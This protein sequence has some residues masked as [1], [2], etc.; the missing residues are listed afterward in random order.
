[1]TARPFR[2][3]RAFTLIELLVV[4]AI[5]AILIGLLL[6][7]VQKVRDAAAR[8]TSSNNLKQMGLAYANHAG[9]F[10]GK[11]IGR[12]NVPVFGA[13]APFAELLPY[14]E[15]N[16]LYN[17]QFSATATQKPGGTPVKTF[18]SPTDST[19]NTTSANMSYT[20]NPATSGSAVSFPGTFTDGTSNT[21][22]FTEHVAACPGGEINLY[23]YTE[24]ELFSYISG[25]FGALQKVPAN[26]GVTPN[27]KD[28]VP[29][30]PSTTSTVGILVALGDGSVR[31]VNQSAALQNWNAACSPNGGETLGSDW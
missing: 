25:D 26:F 7:A 27:K 13:P 10:D 8:M 12:A 1:M 17:Q 15:Q 3:A 22:V 2:R 11:V 6:P 4:I 28:V 16:N 21:I 18:I 30:V 5:I 29:T 19:A 23:S 24:K 9:A 20:V 31:M 14:I